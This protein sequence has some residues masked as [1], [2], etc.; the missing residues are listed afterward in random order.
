MMAFFWFVLV[1]A[2]AIFILWLGYKILRKAGF[3]GRLTVLLLLPVVN[4]LAIWLFAFSKWPNLP[5]RLQQDID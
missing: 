2:Y 4:I 1:P 5:E 3:D